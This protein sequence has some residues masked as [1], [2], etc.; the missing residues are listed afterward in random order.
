MP[1]HTHW[2]RIF[3]QHPTFASAFVL[4]QNYYTFA[5]VFTLWLSND[6]F[7]AQVRARSAK[8]D[9][10][11]ASVTI[12]K[13][14]IE[15]PTKKKPFWNAFPV[16]LTQICQL[17][18]CIHIVTR[19]RYNVQVRFGGAREKYGML[20]SRILYVQGS[21]AFRKNK[22]KHQKLFIAKS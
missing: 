5:Q 7:N 13:V 12:S 22:I 8:L 4:S 9:G 20:L 10:A 14:S 17:S 16:F 6:I 18:V 2:F 1:L 15:R 11:R 19:H 21:N 3:A